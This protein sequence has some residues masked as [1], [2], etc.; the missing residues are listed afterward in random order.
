MDTADPITPRH[1]WRR[2]FAAF[3]DFVLASLVAFILVVML[4]LPE[5]FVPSVPG[6]SFGSFGCRNV[7]QIPPALAAR[8]QAAEFDFNRIA[9]AQVCHKTSFGQ[10]TSLQFKLHFDRRATEGGFRSKTI[11]VEITPDGQ[12]AAR[13]APSGL[14]A[15]LIWMAGSAMFARAGR[16]SPGK[17]L[18]GLRIAPNPAPWAREARKL[19]PLVLGSAVSLLN[20]LMAGEWLLDLI[21]RDPFLA[22]S[23]NP[24]PVSVFQGIMVASAGVMVFLLWY[25]LWPFIRWNGAARHDRASGSRVTRG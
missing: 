4:P 20:S 17:A 23:Q 7:Q 6:I 1:F 3:V 25:Y 5:R 16:R 9:A 18:L 24:W 11:A 14:L 8:L 15:L 22:I 13:V 12:I 10:L 2:A 21:V 19:W